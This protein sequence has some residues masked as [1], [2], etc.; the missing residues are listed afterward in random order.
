MYLNGIKLKDSFILQ[1]KKKKY[2]S[3]VDLKLEIV[4]RARAF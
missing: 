3:A 4:K 1:E 2:R